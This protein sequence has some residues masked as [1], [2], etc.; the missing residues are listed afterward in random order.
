MERFV[1][2]LEVTRRGEVVGRRELLR[3]QPDE[4]LYHHDFKDLLFKDGV[5]TVTR[6]P[7]LQGA[8][9]VVSLEELLSSYTPPAP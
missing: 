6:R 4:I 7:P 3:T 8:L 2:A 9:C 1:L 5:I